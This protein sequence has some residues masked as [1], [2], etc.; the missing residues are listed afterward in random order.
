MRAAPILFDTPL[1]EAA[2]NAALLYRDAMILVLNKPAGIAV[3][4]TGHDKIALDQS[5]HYLQFGLPKPPALA[6]RLDR[7]TSGCLVLGRHRQALIKLGKLFEKQ[8]V[9]KT[10]R[11]VCVGVPAEA[12]GI[13]RRPIL[14]SGVGSKWKM[15]LDDAGQEAVTEYRVLRSFQTGVAGDAGLSAPLLRGSQNA[16][17]HSGGGM[18]SADFPLTKI[19]EDDFNSPARG[20][21]GVRGADKGQFLSEIEFSPKTGRTHQI[22]LHAA[23]ALGCPIAGDPFYGPMEGEFAAANMPMMLHAESVEIPL[24]PSKPLI[25]VTA[26]LPEYWM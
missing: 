15:S 20:E 8:R 25:K 18:I 22:R 23:F 5:F 17:E 12:S 1:S 4:I 24:Q 21:W 14:K 19:V 7:G 16:P 10:Y 2:I 26:P 3:H 9:N 11:A 6:H 13:I